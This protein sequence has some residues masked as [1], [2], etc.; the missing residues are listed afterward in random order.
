MSSVQQKT[1]FIFKG[2]KNGGTEVVATGFS[3]GGC[4]AAADQILGAVGG[5]LDSLEQTED[6]D[7][8]QT[9]TEHEYE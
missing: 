6:W 5:A 2:P 9:V 7:G 1:R 4:K 3:G 8:D